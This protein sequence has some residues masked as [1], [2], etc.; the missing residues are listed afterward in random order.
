M[1]KKLKKIIEFFQP[2]VIVKYK[3]AG[4]Y[5]NLYRNKVVGGREAKSIILAYAAFKKAV[6]KAV[7]VGDVLNAQNKLIAKSTE[8]FRQNN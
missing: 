2:D 7:T 3:S 5:V 1:L 4:R 8:I 6:K